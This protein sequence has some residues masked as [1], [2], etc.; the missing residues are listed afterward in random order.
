MIDIITD[1][2]L[3]PIVCTGIYVTVLSIVLKEILFNFSWPEKFVKVWYNTSITV[4]NLEILY[5]VLCTVNTCL[6]Y[7]DSS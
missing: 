3:L 1:E 7:V 6:K 5:F 4:N 2:H